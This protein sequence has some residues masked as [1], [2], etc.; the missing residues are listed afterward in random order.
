MVALN[1]QN[2][3]PRQVEET[4]EKAIARDYA[5]AWQAMAAAL[6]QNRT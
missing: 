4:T 2:A 3:A 6:E 5:A 1:V